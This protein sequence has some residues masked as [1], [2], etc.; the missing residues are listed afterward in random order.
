MNQLF[1][2]LPFGEAFKQIWEE[3]MEYRK[4]ARY[5]KYTEIGLRKTFKKLILLSENNEATA[6]QMLE[7]AMENNWQGFNF[8]L[9]DNGTNKQSIGNSK[10][11]AA[12]NFLETARARF[13]SR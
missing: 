1:E 5:K 7:R 10:Q 12:S 13:T 6:I 11:Q 4:Q 2:Y 9:P 3:W 8:K